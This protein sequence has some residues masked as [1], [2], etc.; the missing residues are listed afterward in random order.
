MLYAINRFCSWIP[1]DIVFRSGGTPPNLLF[2]DSID[3]GDWNHGKNPSPYP[4][5][6]FNAVWR[7]AP[8]CPTLDFSIGSHGGL[9]NAGFTTCCEMLSEVL[10]TCKSHPDVIRIHNLTK[11]HRQYPKEW[12]YI[13]ERRWILFQKLHRMGRLEGRGLALSIALRDK[14]NDWCELSMSL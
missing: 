8:N 11:P 10:N 7:D 12:Q 9:D 2:S 1:A 6:I 14:L 4:P 13:L 5:L 3:W